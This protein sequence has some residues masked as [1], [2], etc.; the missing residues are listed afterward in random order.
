VALI[1]FTCKTNITHV[2]NAQIQLCKA[3]SDL[4]HNFVNI[5][6]VYIILLFSLVAD[7]IGSRVYKECGTLCQL[8]CD[9]YKSPPF[10]SSDCTPTCVCPEGQVLRGGQC[11]ETDRCDGKSQYIMYPR[12]CEL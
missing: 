6:L 4:P 5:C 7:C 10:C 1:Y 2:N 9:N 11:I 8:T 3:H 12:L